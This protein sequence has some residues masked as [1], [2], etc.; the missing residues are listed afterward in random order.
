MNR[1]NLVSHKRIQ[2]DDVAAFE[3]LFR[4]FYAPLCRYAMRFVRD[5]DMAEE[6]VQDF[7]YHYWQNRK[8]VDI[9][10]NV[11][12]YLF[13]SVR[14]KA[15]K[16]LEH[17]AVRQ[18]HAINMAGAFSG[19]EEPLQAGALE[20]KDLQRIIDETLDTLPERCSLI[21]KMSRFEGMT[22]KEIAGELS[23]SVKTV[24]ANMG[25]AL[26]LFRTKLEKYKLSV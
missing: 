9:N 13:R 17:A 3:S 8:A 16:H 5:T 22:Y 1:I 10:T 19:T 25:K 11:K 7:F 14:N 18:R 15:L 6:I 2:D 12:G 21:F 23:I 24:E 26:Q 4:E 20:A